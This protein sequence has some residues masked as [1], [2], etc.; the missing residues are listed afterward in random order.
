MRQNKP[1]ELSPEFWR[2]FR[3]MH[4]AR[5]ATA[6]QSKAIDRPS[7]KTYAL[8]LQNTWN[9]INFVQLEIDSDKILATS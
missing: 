3:V 8:P 9:S 5:P 2:A 6:A 1:S 4:V 7:P